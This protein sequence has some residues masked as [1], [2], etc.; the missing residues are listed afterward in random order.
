MSEKFPIAALDE[1]IYFGDG[2]LPRK[3]LKHIVERRK[4]AGKSSDYLKFLF[5]CVLATVTNCD[6][7]SPNRNSRHKGSILRVKTFGAGQKSTVVV[8]D[9]KEP[10]GLRK[11][12]TAFD[13]SPQGI[14]SLKKKLQESTSG[15][16]PRP[17][18]PG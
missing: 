9:K 1:A 16:T 6:F 10:N 15:E 11:I 7:E 18:N 3:Q 13:K 12:L 14:R 2:Y 5:G 4:I 17:G 8:M